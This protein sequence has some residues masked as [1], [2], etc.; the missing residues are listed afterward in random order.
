VAKKRR[1]R[2]LAVARVK[3]S[4]TVAATPQSWRIGNH[5]GSNLRLAMVV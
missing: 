1:R 4:L 2:E 5:C 3:C